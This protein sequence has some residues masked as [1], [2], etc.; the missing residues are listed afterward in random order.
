MIINTTVNVFLLFYATTA[1]GLSAGLAGAA[2]ALGLVLDAIADP[3][4]GLLSDNLRSRWGR[5]LPFMLAALPPMLISFVLL[6]SLPDTSNQWLLFTLLA[7]LSAVVRITLSIFNLPYLAAGA[8]LSDDQGER[9]GII[10]LRWSIGMIA[11]FA[12]VAIG[13]GVYLKEAGGIADRQNYAPFTLTMSI[14]MLVMALMAMYAVWRTLDR[15]HAIESK[16]VSAKALLDELRELLKS[17]SFIILFGVALLFATAQGVTQSLGLHANT[18]FWHLSTDQTQM[19]TLAL[20]GGLVLGAP[21]AGPIIARMEYRSASVIG[22]AGLI[23]MQAVPATLKLTGVMTI[24]GQAL[25]NVLTGFALFGGIMTT[26]AA[27]AVLTM[28]TNAADEHEFLFG[29]RREGS[30]FAGW[31]LAIKA[32]GGLGTLLS[33]LALQAIDFPV[34]QT[35]ELGIGIELP[36]KMTNALGLYYGPGAAV[37][38]VMSVALL[39]TFHLDRK[40][41]RSIM[42][43]LKARSSQ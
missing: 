25:A 32:A 41:H 37:F 30:Y 4:I 43:K 21:I 5:R 28:I 36:Q 24:Q 23:V 2:I 16:P 15:Q 39:S 26:I 10:A 6:F 14:I 17:R 12:T 22:L 38:T 9:E 20:A 13:F 3:L 18:F 29:V 33:G 11:A 31:S 8:E 1:C 35:K 42:E 40:A 34:Q 27:I 7:T 19:I